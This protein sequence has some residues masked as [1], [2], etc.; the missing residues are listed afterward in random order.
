MHRDDAHARTELF[1]YCNVIIVG[2]RH[3]KRWLRG[4]CGQR[5]IKSFGYP[6]IPTRAFT[7]RNSGYCRIYR[8]EQTLRAHDVE[9]TSFQRWCWITLNWF[10][11]NGVRLLEGSWSDYTDAQTD[12]I[13]RC[14]YTI[15][16]EKRF[17]LFLGDTTFVT[18]RPV[19]FIV[20][21]INQA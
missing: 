18:V 1:V 21:Y 12:L 8:R 14:L 17:F 6:R 19:L 5:R 2:P 15:Y 4:I 11:F 9:T 13:L 3:T 20:L 7:Y 16:L 10:C